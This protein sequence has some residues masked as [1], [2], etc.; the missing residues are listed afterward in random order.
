MLSQPNVPCLP[1]KPVIV[2]EVPDGSVD[3]GLSEGSVELEER[4]GEDSEGEEN[5][6]RCVE[7]FPLVV[8]NV[9]GSNL[10]P[11]RAITTVLHYCWFIR[12][13]ILIIKK[14][15]NVLALNIKYH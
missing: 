6:S 14:M 7:R 15:K 1:D 2:G 8:G 5:R 13:K 4:N 3:G 11:N 10:D 12:S 9:M